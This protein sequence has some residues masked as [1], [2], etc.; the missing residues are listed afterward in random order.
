M[1]TTRVKLYKTNPGLLLHLSTWNLCTHGCS[2]HDTDFYFYFFSRISHSRSSCFFRSEETCN[3]LPSVLSGHC[4]RVSYAICNDNRK[5]TWRLETGR[6]NKHTSQSPLL[7][8]F[9]GLASWRWRVEA[10]GCR[11]KTKSELE[12]LCFCRRSC[13]LWSFQHWEQRREGGGRGNR[14]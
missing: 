2:L 9:A 13:C 4:G 11:V 10:R 3:T 5:E 14:V 7:M 12:A 1:L 8:Y 6:V